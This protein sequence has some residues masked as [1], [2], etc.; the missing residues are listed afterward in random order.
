MNS[1]LFFF[2]IIL[3]YSFSVNAQNISGVVAG[4]KTVGLEGATIELRLTIDSSIKKIGI[5][6]K[7]GSFIFTGIDAGSYFI[8]V[9]ALGMIPFNT[10]TF[11]LS[12]HKVNLGIIHLKQL[13]TNLQEVTINA[14]KPL[15]EVLADRT[16]LNIAESVTSIGD[17]VLELLRKSPGVQLG[18]DDELSMNGKNGVQVYID[19]KRVPLAGSDLS[20][21]LKG[22]T[23][24]HIESIELITNPSVKYDAAGN[25]GIINI[26][27]KKNK[28]SG[29]NGSVNAGYGIGKYPKYNG[30]LSFNFR[31]KKVNFYSSFNYTW[32]KTYY[33][34]G[35]YRKQL[36]TVYDQHSDLLTSSQLLDYKAGVDISLKKFSSLGLM[37]TGNS[38]KK[39]INIFSGIDILYFPSNSLER[40]LK[41]DNQ[42]R[43]KKYNTNVNLNYHLVDTLGREL[44]VDVD[45]GRF[46]LSA[47]QLQPNSFYDKD[48][49]FLYSQVYNTVAPSQIDIY[50]AKADYAQ[51]LGKGKLT[52]GAKVAYVKSFN[53][54]ERFNVFG[55]VKEKDSVR[56]NS[57]LYKEN[58]NALYVSYSRQINMFMLQAGLRVE[59]THITGES[60]GFIKQSGSF[61]IFDSVFKRNYTDFFPNVSIM[62]KKNPNMLWQLSYGRRIDR[63]VYQDLNPFEF[64]IDEYD[65]MQGN[66]N[67]RPQY[68]QNLSLS[69]TIRG[70]LTSSFSYSH[71]T[72][73]ITPVI[74]TIDGN[75]GFITRKNLAKQDII[76][77]NINYPLMVK[78]Y[79]AF[80][81]V[82][83]FYSRYFANLGPG[84]LIDLDVYALNLNLQQTARL[85]KGI[86]VELAGFYSSPNIWSGTFKRKGLWTVSSGVQKQLF[87]NKATLKIS[88][89]DIF[90]SMRI[91]GTS[92]FAGQYLRINGRSESRQ[93]KLNFTYRFGKNTGTASLR[94]TGVE[95]ESER[96][97]SQG[98]GGMGN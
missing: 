68:T 35:Q 42:T 98:S 77:L 89:S 7:N 52:F 92:D 46:R 17:N 72:D 10:P 13:P 81:N 22:I 86:S 78:W 30:G 8:S 2:L 51:K 14:N 64:I 90:N 43:N 91:I 11:T 96:V 27:L 1:R 9:R 15:V 82:H 6:Q 50:S 31:N 41:A 88:V 97:G 76:G 18:K 33:N 73:V 19:G 37:V 53:D 87:K 40:I 67:L 32:N 48:R 49:H 16:V 44:N 62:L 65:Y 29:T 85:G 71:V 93:F 57:F 38:M 59:N 80:F 12:S 69:N 84:R 54:F 61:Q 28:V 75:K 79:N 5:S 83:S 36:D 94:K 66:T 70:K 3:I 39:D 26:R 56:S 63:P 55:F 23:S 4:D 24:I 95:K 21:Y 60:A 25:A 58:V 47:D 45:Y 34:V 74:D 20:D